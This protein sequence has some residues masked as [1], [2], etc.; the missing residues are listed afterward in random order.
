MIYL[1]T[2]FIAP[3]FREEKLSAAVEACLA[4]QSAGTL[5]ISQWT[6]VEFSSVMARDV[7]MGIIAAR[8]ALI[9]LEAFDGFAGGSLHVF[10]PG[11]ADYRLADRFIRD[12]GT[13]LRAG[14]ALHLAIAR[15]RDIAEIFTL[16]EGMLR[17]ARR[18]KIRAGRKIR[19]PT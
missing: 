2:S 10:A 17:A 14:D 1:D 9:A 7:R 15:Q 18:L 5:A 8:Q 12:F 3:L 19:I 16:D 4:R 6:C 13:C 11:A